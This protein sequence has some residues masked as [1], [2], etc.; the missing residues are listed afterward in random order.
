M[1]CPKNERMLNAPQ[2]A[3]PGPVQ[4]HGKELLVTD[5]SYVLLGRNNE[6]K[7]HMGIACPP[8]V[9]RGQHPSRNL[10]HPPPQ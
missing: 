9:G 10:R 3:S 7:N 6:K 4:F 2:P 8:S 5:I 1:I